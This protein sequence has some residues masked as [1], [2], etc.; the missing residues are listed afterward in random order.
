MDR[1]ALTDGSGRWFNKERAEKWE[2]S[3]TWNG[4]NHISDITGSQF[5]H[6]VLYRTAGK[7]WILHSWSNWQGTL[8][9]WEEV[10]RDFAAKWLSICGYQLPDLEQELKALEV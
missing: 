4:Q 3:T 8:D 7:M 1:V 10:S 5:D 9:T 2:E 6:Q